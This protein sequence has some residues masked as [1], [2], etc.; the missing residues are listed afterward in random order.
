M[1]FDMGNFQVFTVCILTV[2]YTQQ[3]PLNCDCS[4]Y[5]TFGSTHSVFGMSFT[6]LERSSSVSPLD[7]LH[8]ALANL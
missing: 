7:S 1:A 3:H 8:M 4:G 6:M 2:D 5:D